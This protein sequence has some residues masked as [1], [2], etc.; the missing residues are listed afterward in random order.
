M[1]TTKQWKSIGVIALAGVGLLMLASFLGGRVSC[2]SSAASSSGLDEQQRVKLQT[3]SRL[4]LAR[5]RHDEAITAAETLMTEHADDPV[6]LVWGLRIEV[7]ALSCKRRYAEAAKVVMRVIDEHKNDDQLYTGSFHYPM[8][9]FLKET[10][11]RLLA[12]IHSENE[13]YAAAIAAITEHQ[14]A[15]RECIAWAGEE[16]NKDKQYLPNVGCE[17]LLGDFWRLKGDSGQAA[18]H[19]TKVIDYVKMHPWPATKE[20]AGSNSEFFSTEAALRLAQCNES[21]P[22]RAE[23]LRNVDYA[24]EAA[25]LHEDVADTRS[26]RAHWQRAEQ[27]YKNVQEYLSTHEIPSKLPSKLNYEELKTKTLPAALEK[28]AKAIS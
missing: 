25:R 16:N 14:S 13:D 2:A 12:Q 10:G 20:R 8:H 21:S 22:M 3:D 4:L 1:W 19:Y 15:W 7:E 11:Y 6:L 5:G 18:S 28:C 27:I 24:I 26:C 9:L 23:F 17:M